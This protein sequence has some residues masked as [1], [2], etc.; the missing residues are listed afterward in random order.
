MGMSRFCL[1]LLS[2]VAMGQVAVAREEGADIGLREP[3][4]TAAQIVK[5]LG[6]TDGNANAK[7]RD[8]L[9]VR[10]ELPLR[11]G[12]QDSVQ[13]LKRQAFTTRDNVY[14][15]EQANARTRG[16]VL[17]TYNDEQVKIADDSL[18]DRAGRVFWA[19]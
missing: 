10:G 6:V 5:R 13:A 9:T 3:T 17:H 15:V 14:T 2:L 18:A 19:L 12:I 7:R 11:H 4:K 16:F 8:W 1:G